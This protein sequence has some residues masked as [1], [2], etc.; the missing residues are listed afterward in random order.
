MISGSQGGTQGGREFSPT[1]SLTKLPG[2]TSENATQGGRLQDRINP[3][4]TVRNRVFE[5][6]ELPPS[7]PRRAGRRSTV[8]SRRVVEHRGLD[9]VADSALFRGAWLFW[10]ESV[11]SGR[12]GTPPAL[13][14]LPRYR[15]GQ[16][17]F[18]GRYRP[19]LAR[20]R[21]AGR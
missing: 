6:V 10:A 16:G 3:R 19:L 13:G 9:G 21:V 7:L 12:N 1:A 17:W 20:Y 11:E 5:G 14:L 15:A 8:V 4:E 2:F 18:S